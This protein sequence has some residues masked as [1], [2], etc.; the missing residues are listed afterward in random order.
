MFF[1]VVEEV[2]NCTIFYVSQCVGTMDDV[3]QNDILVLNGD[4][5]RPLRK[6]LLSDHSISVGSLWMCLEGD[7]NQ[8]IVVDRCRLLSPLFNTIRTTT[9]CISVN[10]YIKQ[11]EL[12][13]IVGGERIV[14]NNSSF[15][16]RRL[17]NVLQ[18]LQSSNNNYEKLFTRVKELGQV[19]LDSPAARASYDEQSYLSR[20][21]LSQQ[22]D[23]VG[24]SE[25]QTG[26]IR[27][28]LASTPSGSGKTTMACHA[29]SR[30]LNGSS[31][32]G[33]MTMIS[34]SSEILAAQGSVI[35]WW[36]QKFGESS[37]KVVKR[38]WKNRLWY[39]CLS[40]V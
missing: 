26:L 2:D 7:L 9:C 16:L 11:V 34:F 40:M 8:S 24:Q 23:S 18:R 27:I 35:S 20:P 32:H 28:W 14:S 30:W 5:R 33:E 1:S 15:G 17:Q 36:E 37:L 4:M 25:N 39:V 12:I 29:V 6:T 13:G 10:T 3:F 31:H 38:L 22:L 19:L 21:R